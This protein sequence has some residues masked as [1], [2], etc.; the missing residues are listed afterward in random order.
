MTNVS[1]PKF[2]ALFRNGQLM[3]E[4]IEGA[5]RWGLRAHVSA[6]IPDERYVELLYGLAL[7]ELHVQEVLE[8]DLT[9]SAEAQRV[10]AGS[11]LYVCAIGSKASSRDQSKANFWPKGELN[12]P[13]RFTIE[14]Q[15]VLSITR[16]TD[17]FL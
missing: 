3:L 14:T 17:R 8:V 16:V 6:N 1:R 5:E 9:E 15:A 12:N 10:F 2:Y 4:W 11:L 13:S 7:R